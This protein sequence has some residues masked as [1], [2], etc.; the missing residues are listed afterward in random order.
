MSVPA[1]NPALT[2]TV[3]LAAHQRGGHA[4]FWIVGWLVVLAVVV[5][6]IV[7]VIARRRRHSQEPDHPIYRQPGEQSHDR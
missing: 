6:V 5:V 3:L 7:V 4:I 1:A 2:G